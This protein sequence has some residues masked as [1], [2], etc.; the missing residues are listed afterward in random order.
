IRSKKNTKYLWNIYLEGMPN[1][2]K[3]DKDLIEKINTDKIEFIIHN[4]SHNFD[5]TKE[6]F[7]L[8]IDFNQ[9]FD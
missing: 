5:E 9:V 7:T 4:A 1:W 3:F 2:S 8:Y 6:E